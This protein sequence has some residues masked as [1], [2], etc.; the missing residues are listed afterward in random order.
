MKQF[1]TLTVIAVILLSAGQIMQRQMELS[2]KLIRLHVVANSDSREDQ[3]IKLSVRDAV[4]AQV[5]RETAG[6]TDRAQML[7]I[8]QSQLPELERAAQLELD[9]IGC[10]DRV[11]VTLGREHFPTRYYETF[12][13]PAGQY[14]ALRVQIGDGAGQNWW[15]VAFPTLCTAAQQE[16]LEAI[17]V[18][19]GFGADEVAM[20]TES[21]SYEI[22][23]KVLEWW[24]KV[25]TLFAS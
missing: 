3:Q 4:L 12:T 24:E 16:E 5:E 9:E 1:F 7:R 15:C 13:L 10:S 25:M 19:C 18:S 21:Q 14:T 20:I 11:R 22:D 6:C 17:A 2:E 8:L 23:F